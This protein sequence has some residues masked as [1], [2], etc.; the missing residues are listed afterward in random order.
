M[1]SQAT[2]LSMSLN[3]KAK[4]QKTGLLILNYIVM[5]L[6]AAFFLFP[7]WVMA[8]ASFKPEKQIFDD[9]QSVI[10]AFIPRDITLDNYVYIFNRIPFL[11][12]LKNT[13]VIILTT[14]FSGLII[15]SMIAFSLARLKW[16]GKKLVVG[17]ILALTIVPLETIVVPLL[18]VSNNLPWFNGATSW[19][20]SIHVQI[21]PFICDA[22]SI[23]LF[24]QSFI[25]IPKD[26]DEAATLDG[27]NPFIV[28]YR[29]IVPLARSTFVAVAIIQ[30]IFL[31]SAYLWPL[32]VTRTEAFRP[33]TLGVTY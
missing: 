21:I 9:L 29:I 11:T 32:M 18:M 25:Q 13:L 28:Y 12:Y 6:L 8:V 31:W 20:D 30:L 24:Y 16:K 19:L 10:F 17:A 5:I 14:I 4:I 27:A 26:F 22:F 23:F 15:N 3:Q 7:F 33:L 2:K 1:Q